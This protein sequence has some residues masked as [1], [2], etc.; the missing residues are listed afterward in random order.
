[1]QWNYICPR[2]GEW[3]M[4]EWSEREQERK[5]HRT[6][7]AYAPP[8]PEQQHTAFVNTHEWPPQMEEAVIGAKGD[9]CTAPQCQTHYQT[10]DHHIPYTKGGRTSVEN[11]NPMCEKHNQE[12]SDKNPALWELECLV[13]Q[14]LKKRK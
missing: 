11:L 2:C 13:D 10:L 3:R 1:M 5:C 9:I 8:S 6:G 4:V 12:K 14:A 7:Q